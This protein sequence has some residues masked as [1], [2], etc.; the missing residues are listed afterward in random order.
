MLTQA[1]ENM[2]EGLVGMPGEGKILNG[3][4]HWFD[5]HFVEDLME[6]LPPPASSDIWA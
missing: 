4:L 5:K 6:L 2:E 3:A 1:V